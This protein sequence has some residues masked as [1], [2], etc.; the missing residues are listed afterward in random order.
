MSLKKYAEGYFFILR[1]PILRGHETLLWRRCVLFSMYGRI[2]TKPITYST[3]CYDEDNLERYYPAWAWM[4]NRRW[5][6]LTSICEK[7]QMCKLRRHSL[8]GLWPVGM[9][10]VRTQEQP[11]FETW[12][13]HQQTGGFFLND[14][15]YDNTINRYR[16]MTICMWIELV[17]EKSLLRG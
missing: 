5:R 14:I 7:R 13:T 11:F 16:G 12:K 17:L 3:W 15:S 8:N 2:I 6:L 4:Y 1:T 9:I 10:I